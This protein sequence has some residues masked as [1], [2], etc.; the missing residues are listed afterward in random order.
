MQFLV[1]FL[2]VLLAIFPSKIEKVEAEGELEKEVDDGC[3]EPPGNG[4][5]NGKHFYVYIY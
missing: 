5:K 1:V 2:S 3:L 4:I